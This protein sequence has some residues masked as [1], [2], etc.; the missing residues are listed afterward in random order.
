MNDV[1]W[2][3]SLWLAII[4]GVVVGGCVSQHRPGDF[5]PDQLQWIQRNLK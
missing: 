3:L 4:S 5:A 1:V 2:V